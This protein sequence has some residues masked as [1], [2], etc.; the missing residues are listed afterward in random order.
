MNDKEF[1]WYFR[2]TIFRYYNNEGREFDESEL[3]DNIKKHFRFKDIEMEYIHELVRRILS[4]TTIVS[5]I[6]NKVI[7]KD[8][9]ERYQCKDCFY[10]FYIA[11]SEASQCARCNSYNLR[12]FTLKR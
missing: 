10:T 2:D 1:E 6:N 8:V 12:L 9:L 5:K 3:V 4:N 11:K 7:V